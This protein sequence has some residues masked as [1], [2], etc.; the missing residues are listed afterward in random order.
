MTEDHRDDA[1]QVEDPPTD[2]AG[3]TTPARPKAPRGRRDMII[4]LGFL[5]VA[6]VVAVIIYFVQRQGPSL[7]SGWSDNLDTTLKRAKST[8]RRVVVCFVERPPNP[9]TKK[10]IEITFSKEGNRTALKEGK[11][12][13]AMVDWKPEYKLLF[14][15]KREDLPVTL[16][17]SP[18]GKEL[19]RRT[20]YIGEVPFR[21]EFLSLE[22]VQE[23]PE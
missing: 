22:K 9:D 16:I 5:A 1:P 8:Q 4:K 6:I 17:L 20:G 2:P 11:F 18:E 23:R 21:Q 12:L 13:P 10:L 3:K 15:V 19:N 14:K 7:P